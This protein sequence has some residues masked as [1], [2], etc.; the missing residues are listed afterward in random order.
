MFRYIFGCHCCE[1]TNK[2]FVCHAVFNNGSFVDS[3]CFFCI[4]SFRKR[5]LRHQTIQWLGESL[6]ILITFFPAF[7][8]LVLFNSANNACNNECR[9]CSV[10]RVSPNSAA[11]R[12]SCIHTRHFHSNFPT[13]PKCCTIG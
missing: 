13:F 3:N 7:F 5:L 8:L 4:Y 10:V 1:R 11:N 9:P 6:L 2:A 12:S